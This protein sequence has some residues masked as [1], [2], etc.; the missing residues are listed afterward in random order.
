VVIG[1]ACCGIWDMCGV[2]AAQEILRQV[3]LV[4]RRTFDDVVIS[5]WCGIIMLPVQPC[6]RTVHV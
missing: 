1:P 4:S 3:V 2:L 5:E 6:L